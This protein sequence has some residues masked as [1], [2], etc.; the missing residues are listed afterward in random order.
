MIVSA[1][2]V[3]LPA[4]AASNSVKSSARELAKQG[5]VAYDA[6]RFEEAADILA[7]AYEVVHVPTLAVNEARALVKLGKWVAASELYLEATNIPQDKSWQPSQTVAQRDAEKERAALLPRIPR[8]TVFVQN[9]NPSEVEVS[10]D[11]NGLPSAL[12][13]NEQLQDP[14][15]YK[16]QGTRGTETVTET[17]TVKEGD[18]ANVTLRF[19]AASAV[20]VQPGSNAPNQ[21][22][23]VPPPQ[24]AAST[25]ATAPQHAAAALSTKGSTQKTIGWISIGVGG[26]G[27][28]VGGVTGF[29]AM[30][31]RSS[32]SDSGSC[33]ADLKHC[34]PEL[35][36]KV[37][38]YNGL[39]TVSTIGLYAGGVL[40]V[41]GVTLLLTSPKQESKPTV[42]L[43]LSPNGAALTGGF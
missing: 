10:I 25:Q 16:I 12:I 28:I 32:L 20:V 3:S 36:S 4:L 7:K 19:N 5:L 6:G 13:G 17:I 35:D 34:S 1:V 33:S 38:T 9:A 30:S 40:A 14:G 26:A 15:T 42:V 23:N 27:L 43:W 2:L 37:R 11:G 18:R 24:T 39:R 29:M 22:K 8:F 21:P 41:A 31:K